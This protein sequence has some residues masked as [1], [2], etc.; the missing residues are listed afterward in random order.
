MAD[1]NRAAWFEM[2]AELWPEETF[3]AH[4]ADIDERH[5]SATA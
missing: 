4:A 5:K 3:A 1:A 2:R